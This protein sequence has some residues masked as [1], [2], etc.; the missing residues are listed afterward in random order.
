M[1]SPALLFS[2]FSPQP[3]F[4]FRKY[5]IYFS[6]QHSSTLAYSLMWGFKLGSKQQKQ[7]SIDLW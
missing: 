7:N 1:A 5:V 6:T 4:K 2:K 3:P